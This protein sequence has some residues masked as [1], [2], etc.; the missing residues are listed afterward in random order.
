MMSSLARANPVLAGDGIPSVPCPN[1]IKLSLDV[2]AAHAI[3]LCSL[4]DA[5][6]CNLHKQNNT[7]FCSLKASSH[8][9]LKHITKKPDSRP[10]INKHTRLHNPILPNLHLT[11]LP[12]QK[13]PRQRQHRHDL[14]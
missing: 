6:H 5:S 1:V 10:A 8:H 14:A 2:D 3:D 13:R 11:V 9:A 7:T 12:R 4:Q